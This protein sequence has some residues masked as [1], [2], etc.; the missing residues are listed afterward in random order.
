VRAEPVEHL[1][2]CGHVRLQPAGEL[3]VEN[4]RDLRVEAWWR[5]QA[6]SIVPADVEMR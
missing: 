2:E 4:D 1:E 5:A 3:L 6:D